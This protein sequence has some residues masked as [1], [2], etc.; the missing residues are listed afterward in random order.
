MPINKG[1]MS[2]KSAEWE[3]PWEFFHKVNRRFHFTVDVCAT[4]RNRKCMEYFSVKNDALKKKWRGVCWMNPPYGRDIQHW[5][6]KAYVSSR[7]GATV[8]CLIPARTDTA[9][10][11]DYCM[12]GTIYFIRGRL[13]FRNQ[14]LLKSDPAPFPCALVIFGKAYN[15]TGIVRSLERI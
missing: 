14:Y 6:R 2:S 10:W 12:C 4:R 5:I 15:Y 9:W 3:T 7:R 13:T 8:V 1:M 11:H